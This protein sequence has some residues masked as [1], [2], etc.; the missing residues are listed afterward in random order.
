ME[1]VRSHWNTTRSFWC[2]SVYEIKTNNTCE[3]NQC[4]SIFSKDQHSKAQWRSAKS[5]YQGK[6]MPY[7]IVCCLL[8]YIY[9]LWKH[10]VLSPAT[11]LANISHALFPGCLQNNTTFFFSAKHPLICSKTH[12]MTQLGLQRNQKFPPHSGCLLPDLPDFLYSPS[13]TI[14][15][16]KYFLLY[17]TSCHNILAK[18]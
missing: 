18:Q 6:W 15:W 12:H 14:S 7:S 5:K 8:G 9:T 16:N 17:V 10:N 2:D 11:T 3:V 13:E 1:V 4:H